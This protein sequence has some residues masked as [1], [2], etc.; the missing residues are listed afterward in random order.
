MISADRRL[1]GTEYW[2]DA[3]EADT[4]VALHINKPLG[5]KSGSH[6]MDIALKQS[7]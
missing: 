1:P 5:P 6:P 7:E 4:K 2:H 3:P